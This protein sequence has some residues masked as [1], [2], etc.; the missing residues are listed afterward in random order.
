MAKKMTKK[1][2][3]NSLLTLAE[4]KANPDLVKFIE[5]ELELLAKKNGSEKKPTAKQIENEKFKSAI[6]EGM[7]PNQMYTISELQKNIPEIAELTN[8]RISALLTL[9]KDEGLISRS[10]VKRKAY[11]TRIEKV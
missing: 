4:V 6:Y 11:F 2:Y 5:H 1:D 10:E 9:M 7:A 8:Q 3:F